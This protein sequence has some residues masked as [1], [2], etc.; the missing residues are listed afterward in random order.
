MGKDDAFPV[1]VWID[2]IIKE[3]YSEELEGYI[4]EKR[5]NRSA[6]KNRSKSP[7]IN[8]T[9]IK[10]WAMEYFGEYAGWANHYMF[11]ERRKRLLRS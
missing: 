7:S 4:Q 10:E 2:R 5:F 9:I 6:T 11:H 1:D 3:L 8:R